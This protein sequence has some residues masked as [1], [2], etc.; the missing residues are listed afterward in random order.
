MK[1]AVI[2]GGASGMTA[3]VC[4]AKNSNCVTV[5]ER[6][7]K[8]MK[9]ILATGNGRCNLSNTDIS[10]K[11]FLSN[12]IDAV[13][14]ILSLFKK[15]DEAKFFESLGIM[16][17]YEDGRI[18]PRSKRA[19]SVVD[20]LRFEGERLGVKTVTGTE[21]KFI[22]KSNG[23]FVIGEESFNNVIISCGGS[24]AP[25][26]G[27]DGSSFEL[28]KKMGHTINTCRPY[29]VP[30]KTEENVK[31][32]KGIRVSGK[33]TIGELSETGELQFT[34][35]GISGIA[36]MQLSCA[37]E[38]GKMIYVDLFPEINN[39][40]LFYQMKKRLDNLY[41]RRAEDFLTGAVHK[42]LAVYVLKTLGISPSEI[43]KNVFDD[44]TLKR[45]SETLKSL[46]FT[47]KGTLGYKDAQTT[48]GG[49][50]LKEFNPKTLESLIVKGLY[51]TGEALDCAG[52]CGGYNL[53]W[54]WL[55]G[56]IAGNACK[57]EVD[58]A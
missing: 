28:L 47:L 49:A 2:G 39:S 42:L 48:L 21:I 16:F 31:M 20:A 1:T 19:S 13:Q 12:D 37:A 22:K 3:A 44:S 40:E 18:Y 29:L 57:K 30:L 10:D 51:C 33:L 32:L 9:K 27:T 5:F 4:A 58:N 38:K 24:A 11:Y 15:E 26:F 52:K 55:T 35:Y 6:N 46:P 41:Y 43:S 50:S 23:K 17:S 7:D 34:D 45:L 14:K 8:V 54:S 36:A 53:H 25:V 56:Y